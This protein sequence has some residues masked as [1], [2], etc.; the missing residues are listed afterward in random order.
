MN[1]AVI[2]KDTVFFPAVFLA[3]ALFLLARH[4]GH[5]YLDT[6]FSTAGIERL[7]SAMSRSTLV[8]ASLTE[9][10]KNLLEEKDKTEKAHILQ[11]IGC[12]YY[13][14]YK[15]TGNRTQLD[16]ALA[17]I[18]QSIVK[19]PGVARFHYN[20][21]R[22]FTELGDQTRALQQYELALRFDPRHILALSNAGTCAYF[23]FNK[24]KAAAQY[25]GRALAI[26]SLMPMCNVVLGLIGIDEKDF[27]AAR[28]NFEKELVACA[29]A[30]VRNRYP[31]AMENINYA[32]ALSH[33]NLLT[34]YS[35]TFRNRAK[36]KIHLDAYLRLEPV[37]EKRDEAQKE[38]VKYWGTS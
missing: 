27:E 37:Q 34:L 17:F 11:N 6:P 23:A 38:Y 31:L 29:A 30:A 20:F 2:R 21:G 33:R 10:Q 19:G 13:D 26:D 4:A 8:R 25:F 14:L 1:A 35:A 28:A 5:T 12:A 15:E 24:R 22:M 9:L 7:G 3:W 16:S 32:A 36:A 18:H